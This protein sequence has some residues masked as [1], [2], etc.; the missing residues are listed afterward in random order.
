M[1]FLPSKSQ[2]ITPHNSPKSTTENSLVVT[3][4]LVARK[5]YFNELIE[6]LR[7]LMII[8]R[9]FQAILNGLSKNGKDGRIGEECLIEEHVLR[10]IKTVNKWIFF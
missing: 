8:V 5:S 7:Q 3:Q 1:N 6:S 2:V 9:D 4:L 10:Y